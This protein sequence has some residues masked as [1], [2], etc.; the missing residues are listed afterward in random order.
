MNCP[1]ECDNPECGQLYC[2]FCLNM[3]LYDK[4]LQQDQKECEVCRKLGGGY[5]PASALILKMLH[6]YKVKCATCNK[7]FD[8][9]I[10][11]QHEVMCQQSVCS[12]ELCA[13]SLTEPS[14]VIIDP[15]DS[16]DQV[17]ARNIEANTKRI[18]FTI[19]GEEFVACSS[20]CKKVTKFAYMLR[21]QSE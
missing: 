7:P 19:M 6:R 3:K 14:T 4:N 21:Q 12:N 10:L 5:R 16:V 8:L 20:K 17:I 13:V 9:K 11:P 18:K 1:V 2:S 15:N